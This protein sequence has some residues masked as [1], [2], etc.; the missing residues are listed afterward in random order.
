[1]IPA[2]TYGADEI[3]TIK[4]TNVLLVKKGFDAALAEQLVRVLFDHRSELE[5]ASPAA[6]DIRIE[7]ATRTQP[8]PLNP[9]AE[10]ALRALS[11]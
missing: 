9:G 5:A 10:K 6:K 8:V 11:G 3:P 2:D 4:V 7:T 1:V